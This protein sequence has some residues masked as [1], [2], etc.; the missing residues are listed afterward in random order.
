MTDLLFIKKNEE[1]R[2]KKEERTYHRQ[3]RQ[4]CNACTNRRCLSLA[5]AAQQQARVKMSHPPANAV[6]SATRKSDSLHLVFGDGTSSD[7]PY[8]WLRDNCQCA[9][10]FSEGA[11]GRKL[12]MQDL[13]LDVKP[14][15]IS[16]SE[17][18]VTVEWTDGH[19]SEFTGEWLYD[20]AFTPTSR[21][22]RR[23]QFAYTREP[24]GAD[25]RLP[26][27]DYVRMMKDDKVLL[28][29][30]ITM[31]KKGSAMVK[32]AP[33]R[34][35]A[36]PELIEHIAYVKPSHY[37]PHSPVINR[38][39]SNNVAFTNAKL[40]MHND[41]AQYEH[42]PG[43]IFIHCLKQHIGTGGESVIADGLLAA[44]ILRKSNPDAFHVLTSTDAYFWD[45]GHANYSWE[46]PEFYKI[47]RHPILT[48]DSNNDVCRVS[49]NNAVRD[50]FLDLPAQKVKGFY[51]AMKLFN[52]ILYDNSLAFKMDSGDIMTLDNVRCLHGREGYEAF[53]ERHIESSY[54]DWDEARCRRRRLQEKL[55]VNDQK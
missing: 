53:S 11:L 12:L 29:W 21:T 30:L 17:R 41:L 22:R 46:M 7:L 45:K 13:D 51:A 52:D 23:H 35:I 8:I 33:D 1:R 31:E 39:D 15:L 19:Y 26:E 48:L 34:D 40:G 32:N 55:G 16:E 38:P 37:G 3:V 6:M 54:L 9:Q 24:W 25:H 42:M 4:S 10:C 43:I 50:S 44:E 18:V 14:A 47:S 5:A 2:C 49:L 20:R 28:D 36:G 27:Y